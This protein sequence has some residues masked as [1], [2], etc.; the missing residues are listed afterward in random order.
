MKF[1]AACALR[2]ASALLSRGCGKNCGS[3]LTGNVVA[4]T[5]CTFFFT[6]LT[7]IYPADEGGK[8]AGTL[9]PEQVSLGKLNNVRESIAIARECRTLLGANG[10][11]LD[12]P[13]LRHAN[14]LESVLTYEGTSEVHQLVIGQ[15]LTG[16]AAFR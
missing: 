3:S 6:A 12:Y 1:S 2:V 16:Q 10:I 8:D 4:A 13:V 7:S 15:A 14:N 11:T 9:R 5:R